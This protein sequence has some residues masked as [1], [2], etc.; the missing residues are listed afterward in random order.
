MTETPPFPPFHGRERIAIH[1]LAS[2]PQWNDGIKNHQ[3]A[4]KK[5]EGYATSN[6]ED[7]TAF[8]D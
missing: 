4:N 7:L 6:T 1:G 8:T 3:R 2:A 5:P